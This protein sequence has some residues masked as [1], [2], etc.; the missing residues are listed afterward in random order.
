[1]AEPILPYEGP[2]VTRRN[3]IAAGLM[4][5]FSG[6]DKPCKRGHI[7]QRRVADRTCVECNR[8]KGADWRALNRDHARKYKQTWDSQSRR[9][10]E[11]KDKRLV[12]KRR[13]YG[14]IACRLSTQRRRARRR[15]AGGIITQKD[16]NALVARSPRC[17]FL[18]LPLDEILPANFGSHNPPC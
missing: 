13:C 10:R 17:F 15:N 11:N 8:A 16:W 14:S 12:S 4:W 1:M 7:A 3:A 2:I 9:R 6:P 18:R 5:Y